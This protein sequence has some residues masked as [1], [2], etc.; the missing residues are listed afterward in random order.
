VAPAEDALVEGSLYDLVLAA[1]ECTPVLAVDQGHIDTENAKQAV[2]RVVC[3]FAAHDMRTATEY[4]LGSA[5]GLLM[6]DELL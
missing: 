1:D 5:F 2:R 3:R 4:S 6:S